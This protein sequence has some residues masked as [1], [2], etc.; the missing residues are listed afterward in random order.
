MSSTT[1]SVSGANGRLAALGVRRYAV[2]LAVAGL[3]A[4]VL[5]V[6]V[7]QHLPQANAAT[8]TTQLPFDLP[9]PSSLQGTTKKVFAHYWPPMP[10]SIDNKAPDVDYYA[11]NYLT[12][13]GENGKHAAYGGY[14][15][16]R[17]TTHQPSTSTSWRV[18]DLRTEV[19]QAVDGGLDGFAVD[20]LQMPGD[21]DTLVANAVP[22]LLTAA[23]QQNSGFK[24]MLMPDMSGSMANKTVAQWGAYLHQ[25]A[26]SPA[27]YR[28]SDGRLV[29]APFAAEVW[30]VAKWTELINLMKNAYGITVAF[31]PTFVANEQNYSAAF[32]PISYGMSNWGSRN[33]AWTDPTL[34]FAT[35]P[36]GRGV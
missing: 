27:A 1:S 14:L 4:G 10:L 7:V 9:A 23:T 35:S 12:P 13:T 30:T 19:Q 18:D 8:A 28:L 36:T 11:R 21:G 22:N 26:A 29:V 20:I 33:P 32:A 5:A 2:P 15:R 24:I 17:P 16:D 31:M 3:V 25:L 34:T 6:P